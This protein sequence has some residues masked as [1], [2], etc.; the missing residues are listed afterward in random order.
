MLTGCSSID[1]EKEVDEKLQQKYGEEFEVAKIYSRKIWKKY[2]EAKAY[3]KGNS[4]LKFD[5]SIDTDDEN[6]SDEYAEKYIC[7]KITDVIID[8]ASLSED[9]YVFT[10]AVG[11]QPIVNTLPESIE[12]YFDLDKLNRFSTEIFVTEENA[13]LYEASI[14]FSNI[15]YL[16]IT[17]KVYI[18]NKKQLEDVKKYWIDNGK[19]STDLGFQKLTNDFQYKEVKISK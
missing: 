4:D 18:V 5:V 1:R 15:S 12:E 2:Y 13:D 8:N 9:L 7:N 6:F 10:E 17:A 14:L 19:A 3:P 16:N 11:P